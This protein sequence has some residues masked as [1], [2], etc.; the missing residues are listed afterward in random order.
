MKSDAPNLA[1]KAGKPFTL[2][3]MRFEDELRKILAAPSPE[4]HDKPPAKKKPVTRKK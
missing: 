4:K 1:G 2:A 3:P